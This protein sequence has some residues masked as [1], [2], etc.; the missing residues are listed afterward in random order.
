M[1][2]KHTVDACIAPLLHGTPGL[3]EDDT[4]YL[5]RLFVNAAS[6]T[7]VGS[8]TLIKYVSRFTSKPMEKVRLDCSHC[9]VTLADS[10]GL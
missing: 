2:A 7:T 4:V 8:A 1:L 3:S 9:V 6:S 5:A 10:A